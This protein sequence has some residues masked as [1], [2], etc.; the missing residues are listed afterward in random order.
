M[1][2]NNALSTAILDSANGC[3]DSPDYV[4]LRD[5]YLALDTLLAGAHIVSVTITDVNGATAT[6][7]HSF[8]L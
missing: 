7:E 6:A 2:A 3:Y 5:G 4:D 8:S 1:P